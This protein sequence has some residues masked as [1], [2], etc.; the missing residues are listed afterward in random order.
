MSSPKRADLGLPPRYDNCTQMKQPL[1]LAEE[2]T[3]GLLVKKP[4]NKAISHVF[5]QKPPEEGVSDSLV[6]VKDPGKTYHFCTH[7]V[8]P[9][10]GGGG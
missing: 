10:G 1:I 7:A 9:R 3:P 8:P 6:T 2:Q 5:P 4:Q